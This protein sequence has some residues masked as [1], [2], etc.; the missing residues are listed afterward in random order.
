MTPCPKCGSRRSIAIVYGK[1]TLNALKRAN[2]GDVELGGCIV[3]A[4]S[5]AWKCSQCGERHGTNEWLQ[6]L[7]RHEPSNEERAEWLQEQARRKQAKQERQRVL[8]ARL[9]D[10]KKL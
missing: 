6:E 1:P 9:R 8:K 3:T 5:P 2:S 7:K 10:P 4:D